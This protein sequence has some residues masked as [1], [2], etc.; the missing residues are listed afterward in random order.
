MCEEKAI[1]GIKTGEVCYSD[2]HMYAFFSPLTFASFSWIPSCLFCLHI[3]LC[4][5]S[6]FCLYFLSILNT[7]NTQKQ[8]SCPWPPIFLPCP[9]LF[10]L[11][12]E[13]RGVNAVSALLIIKQRWATGA[14]IQSKGRSNRSVGRSRNPTHLPSIFYLILS[15]LLNWHKS[16]TAIIQVHCYPNCCSGI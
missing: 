13:K 6:S 11:T 1:E 10:P 16:S 8:C 15:L 7:K 12:S 4:F 3:S 2:V 5:S 9:H 14:T